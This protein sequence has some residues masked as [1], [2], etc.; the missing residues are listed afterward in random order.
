MCMNIYELVFSFNLNLVEIT[1]ELWE[2]KLYVGCFFKI[3]FKL[4][5]LFRTLLVFL[6][7]VGIVSGSSKTTIDCKIKLNTAFGTDLQRITTCEIKSV[8]YIPGKVLKFSNSTGDYAYQNLRVKFL[9]SSLLSVPNVL[10]DE[11]RKLEIL[12]MNYVGLRNI[13]QKSFV[14]AESLKVFQA[15]GNR[16]SI[17]QAYS[18]AGAENLEAL[19]LSDNIISN[20]HHEAFNGLGNLKELS[21]SNNR[22]SIIDEHTFQPLKNLT[23]IWL[24]RNQIKIIA[25]NLLINSD[26]LKGIYLNDNK[27]SALSTVLFDSLPELEFLFLSGNNCTSKDFVNTK[28]KTNSNVKKELSQCFEEFRTVVPD[29]DEKHRLKHVLRD[30]EK[31][32]ALCES[33]KAALL[34][35]LETTRQELANLQYKNGK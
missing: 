11:F 31:A 28:I 32:N 5:K 4:W 30:A 17:V 14:R 35:R 24:D 21:L 13:F 29:E 8:K 22:L 26:K 25:V 6:C 20:I 27:I 9:E 15:F 16:I 23:W 3:A 12:E 7:I 33:E 19:D 34:V 1:A 18:F 10:F 2:R